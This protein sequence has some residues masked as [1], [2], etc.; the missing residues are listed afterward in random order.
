MT[1]RCDSDRRQGREACWRSERYDFGRRHEP[2]A[3]W[4][5]GLSIGTESRTAT[6]D[7]RSATP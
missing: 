2:S 7:R 3:M 1:E 4:E 5:F 6:A